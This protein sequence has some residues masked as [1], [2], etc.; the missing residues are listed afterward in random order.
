MAIQVL[1]KVWKP[2]V[3]NRYIPQ[4]NENDIDEGVFG[5]NHYKKALYRLKKMQE[6][7]SCTYLITFNDEEYNEEMN[8]H[9][10]LNSRVIPQI[11]ENL[12]S[13]GNKYWDC[14]SKE[15]AKQTILGYEFYIDTRNTKPV[16]CRK[17]QYGPYKYKIILEQVQTLIKNVWIEKCGEP[18]GS[19]IV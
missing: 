7:G 6:E 19:R 4:D 2:K 9:I 1:L 11:K 3:Q 16:F 18:W 13:T 8:K 10:K 15:S 17:P 5:F 12:M 14:F